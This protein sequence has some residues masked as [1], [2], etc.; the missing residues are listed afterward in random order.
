MKFSATSS[1]LKGE[2]NIPADKSI[3]HRAILFC[4]IA[5]GKSII[6]ANTL[7]RD[8]L[9]SIRVMQHLGV[10]IK[11]AF[12][13]ELFKIA[14]EEALV[15]ISLSDGLECQIEI[16]GMGLRGL[17]KPN[18]SL[19]CGNSGTTSRL[20]T[21]VLSGQH[22]SATITG[23]ESLSRRPF[24]RVTEPL[25]QM[26]AKFSGDTL[27]LIITGKELTGI[28]Y[29]SPR[30]SAQVKSAIL[31]AGLYADGATTV[32]EPS[33]S[34]DHTERMLR[35]MGC[36]IQ[37]EETANGKWEVKLAKTPE[38]KNLQSLI[39]SVPGDFSAAAFFI[40]V[41]LLASE[42]KITIKNVGWNESRNGLYDIL[43]RMGA[44]IIIVNAREV[45]GEKVVDIK[46]SSSE[47]CG[48]EVGAVDVVRAIDE[49][50]ILAVAAAAAKG[51]TTITGAQE[52]RVKESDRL[53]LMADLLKSFG[54]S[55]T[56]QEDGLT[57][58]GSGEFKIGEG[59]IRDTWLK[60]G[61]HRIAMS[62]AVMDFISTGEFEILDYK[63]VETS[64]PTFLSCFQQLSMDG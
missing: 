5:N 62:G 55:L 37:E 7:G 50:P 17:S 32:I 64:F 54:V 2:I 6:T 40:V 27:P 41:G 56:E 52:L 47:L 39:M 61:D 23:D 60:S 25:G 49:I 44:N 18:Q 1:R 35:A 12:T 43:L 26:G 30:A 9:A 16:V 63:A 21:G 59:K 3:A 57:I 15:D 34:R 24:K 42:S 22:F 8:N 53:A 14:Q 10:A 38:N 51:T 58:N 36:E 11:A 4:S 33:Q 19:Y 45:G 46:V 29:Q 20:L 28:T 48:V 31:L 13:K